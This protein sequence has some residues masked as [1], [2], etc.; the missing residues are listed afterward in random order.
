MLRLAVAAAVVTA[1]LAAMP[2]YAASAKE[3]TCNFGADSKHLKGPE[4]ARF[5]RNCMAD[6]DDPRGPASAPAPR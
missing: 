2:S 4:R 1:A 5:I 3:E 6:R